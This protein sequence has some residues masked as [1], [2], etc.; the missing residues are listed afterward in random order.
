[1]HP[2]ELN[3]LLY[4]YFWNKSLSDLQLMTQGLLDFIIT[5][6]DNSVLLSTLNEDGDKT[7][8]KK[9]QY[10]KYRKILKSMLS[11]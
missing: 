10:L 9:R 4:L 3:I 11:T 8:Q 7:F 2:L 6:R 5:Y 1:M